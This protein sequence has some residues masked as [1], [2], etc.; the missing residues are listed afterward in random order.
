MDYRYDVNQIINSLSDIELLKYQILKNSILNLKKDLSFEK[1]NSIKPLLSNNIP[2]SIRQ[3]IKIRLELLEDL[4]ND[5][6]SN[7]ISI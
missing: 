4:L 2:F 5:P 7:V 3:H 6:S 1:I